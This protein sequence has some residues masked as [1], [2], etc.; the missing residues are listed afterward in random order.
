[1][2]YL[3]FHSFH[4]H[5]HPHI[6]LT[7]WKPSSPLTSSH[8]SLCNSIQSVF[9]NSCVSLLCVF[10]CLCK[11][12]LLASEYSFGSDMKTLEKPLQSMSQIH[13]VKRII[14]YKNN[15]FSIHF[16]VLQG[17]QK[18]DISVTVRRHKDSSYGSML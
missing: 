8:P 15:W 12:C 7:A 17:Q 9:M 10:L 11:M 16:P 14:Y 5:T 1:M 3:Y 18:A 2:Y 6:F 4:Q 13:H